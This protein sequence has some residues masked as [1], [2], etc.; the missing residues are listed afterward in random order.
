ME[1]KQAQDFSDNFS[2]Q[3]SDGLKEALNQMEHNEDVQAMKASAKEVA[4]AASDF[5]RKY[6]LQSVLGAA[7]IGFILANLINRKK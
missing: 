7:A 6:P 3:L 5:I 2:T 1:K 4:D